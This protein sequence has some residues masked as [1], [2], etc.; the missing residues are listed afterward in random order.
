[1]P[2]SYRIDAAD[3]IIYSRAWG[4]LTDDDIATNRA[5]LARDPAFVPTSSQLYDFSEVTAVEVTAAGVRALART[6]PFA[7]TARRAIVVS[8]DVAYGMA[9]MY[10]I[11]SDHHDDA[12]R[13]FRDQRDAIAWL[14]S[15]SAR[16]V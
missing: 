15:P 2:A 10:A 7:R 11:I 16:A 13:I 6:S 8:S 1:M 14:H 9:R 12:F 4:V 3:Q 5:A